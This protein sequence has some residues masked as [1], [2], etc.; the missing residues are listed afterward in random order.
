[1]SG[2]NPQVEKLAIWGFTYE[3]IMHR[4]DVWA[5][6]DPINRI[7][8]NG[9]KKEEESQPIVNDDKTLKRIE[10]FFGVKFEGVKDGGKQ[11]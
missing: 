11:E 6:F 8:G 10:N 3:E 2:H 7:S 4:W 9:P 5:R 1:M